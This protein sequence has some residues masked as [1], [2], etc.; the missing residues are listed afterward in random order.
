M[1][2][3]LDM[4]KGIITVNFT[5]GFGNNIFQYVFGRL[6][7]EKNNIDFYSP[8]LEQ[9]GIPLQDKTNIKVGPF[10]EKH[11]APRE[12]CNLKKVIINDKNA[13]YYFTRDNLEP[14]H[15]V[16]SGYFED[17][18]FYKPF[19]KT[20]RSWFP[21]VEKTNTE[22]VIIHMRL[23]NRLIQKAHHKNHISAQAFVKA[24]DNFEYKNVHIITDSK[25]WTPY[26]EQDILDLRKEV[27]QGPGAH[28][29][30]V[31]VPRSLYYMNSLIEEFS[32]LNPI[33]HCGGETIPNSGALA[34]DFMKD[35]NFIRSFDKILIFNSTFSWWAALLSEAS[36]VGTYG[37]W[38]AN[39]NKNLGQTQFDNWFSWG[40]K[41]DLYWK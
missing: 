40:S 41:Q 15:Y 22:D 9:L 35:F 11:A 32:K 6:L 37:P 16:I 17:A 7:A 1:E 8:P 18:R 30:W 34:S 39:K 12:H 10:G 19:L 23:Q 21:V 4:S 24:L 13:L 29:E 2:T 25:K 5:V 28:S 14:A 26:D 27:S 38:K 31:D 36:R 33:V 20:I 3:C